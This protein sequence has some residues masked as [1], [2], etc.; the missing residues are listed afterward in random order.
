MGAEVVNC[1]IPIRMK[2][3]TLDTEYS[4]ES[5]KKRRKGTAHLKLDHPVCYELWTK[6]L[7]TKDV[8]QSWRLVGCGKIRMIKERKA[9]NEVEEIEVILF[10]RARKKNRTKVNRFISAAI[11]RTANGV[12]LDISQKYQVF[13]WSNFWRARITSIFGILSFLVF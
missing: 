3:G 6:L 2:D 12:F 8:G 10:Y 7:I 11:C 5:A 4:Q 13:F 1:N 9:K